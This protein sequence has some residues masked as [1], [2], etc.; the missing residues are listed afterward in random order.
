VE[1]VT[2]PEIGF[3]DEGFSADDPIR[4]LAHNLDFWVPAVTR[5]YPR[6][7]EE[8]AR[9]RQGQDSRPVTLEDGSVL[10]GAVTGNPRMG[11]R[12]W[13]GEDDAHDN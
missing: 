10:A 4:L 6:S 2:A 7:A 3:E 5:R 11:G 12:L 9:G 8:S 1:G 13:F